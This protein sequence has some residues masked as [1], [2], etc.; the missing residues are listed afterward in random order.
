MFCNHYESIWAVDE[1]CMRTRQLSAGQA[2]EIYRAKYHKNSTFCDYWWHNIEVLSTC[3][4]GPCHIS[5][6]IVEFVFQV[7]SK[8]EICT[9]SALISKVVSLKELLE[10]SCNIDARKKQA[11]HQ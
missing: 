3:V 8:Y 2:V 5:V 11:K 9:I 6:N 4:S 1:T 7:C 10:E